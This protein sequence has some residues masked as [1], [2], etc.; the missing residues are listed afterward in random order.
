VQSWAICARYVRDGVDGFYSH[1]ESSAFPSVHGDAGLR[2]GL[3]AFHD[4]LVNSCIK[5]I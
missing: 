2:M 4:H 3:R 1:A 5:E